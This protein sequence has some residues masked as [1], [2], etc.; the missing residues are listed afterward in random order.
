LAAEL[1]AVAEV[2]LGVELPAVESEDFFTDA[3]A[4]SF[5]ASF[6]SALEE[7]LDAES[8][9]AVLAE[10]LAVGESLFEAAQGEAWH[11]PRITPKNSISSI[12]RCFIVF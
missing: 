4:D 6:F 3:E 8:L 5:P 2:S 7:L 9:F 12:R 11:P 10:T 1:F